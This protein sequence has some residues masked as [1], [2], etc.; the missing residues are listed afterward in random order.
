MYRGGFFFFFFFWGCWG[1][2]GGGGGGGWGGGGVG[3]FFFFFLASLVKEGVFLSCFSSWG[4]W[5]KEGVK[6]KVTGVKWKC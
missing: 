5:R 6:K 4:R 1:K 3:A 2:G